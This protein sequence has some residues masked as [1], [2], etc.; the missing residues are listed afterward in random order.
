MG[1]T[2]GGIEQISALTPEQQGLFTKLM[3]DFDPTELTDMFQSSVADPARQQFQ[4]KTLPGI[5][6]RFIA[7]GGG[8]SGALNRAA[9]G[10]GAD[11]ESGLS[12]QL[13][14]LL[15]QAQQGTLNRQAGLAVAPTQETFQQ[16]SDDPILKLLTPLLA[17]V[18]TGVGGPL[19]TMAGT[20]IGNTLTAKNKQTPATKV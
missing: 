12:G 8:G 13:A 18:G 20:G 6:E 4:Q 1:G 7:G 2:K 5:Q 14:Q 15:A 11:L 16:M 3:T 9:V 10:A 17:G 19:G